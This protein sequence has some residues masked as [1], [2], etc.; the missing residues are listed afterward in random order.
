MRL[1]FLK[2]KMTEV[3]GKLLPQSCR[4]IRLGGEA[5]ITAADISH[6]CTQSS[7]LGYLIVQA[8]YGDDQSGYYEAVDLIH[9]RLKEE[10]IEYSWNRAITTKLI[11][12]SVYEYFNCEL[13]TDKKR[14]ELIGVHPST[15]SRVWLR[16]FKR[17][18]EI[19]DA[20]EQSTLYLVKN[21]LK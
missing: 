8:R 13:W 1:I 16:R 20:Y 19:L 21:R 14:A 11:K 10:I 5:G 6:A 4:P 15:F 2:P 3:I 17:I 9:V 12:S 7:R 18:F